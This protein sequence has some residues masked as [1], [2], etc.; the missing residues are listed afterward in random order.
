MTIKENITVD[1]LSNGNLDK[2]GYK[3]FVEANLQTSLRLINQD[4]WPEYFGDGIMSGLK[5]AVENSIRLI[6]NSLIKWDKDLDNITQGS[7]AGGKN[8][9]YEEVRKDISNF[10]FKLRNIPILVYDNGDGTYTP[11]NGRTRSEILRTHR[12]DNFICVVYQKIKGTSHKEVLNA[13]SKFSLRSNAEN[14]PAGDLMLADVYTEGCRA[15]EEDW[16]TL[17]GDTFIDNKTVKDRVDEVCGEGIFTELK[18]TYVTQQILNTYKTHHRVKSWSVTGAATDWV[19]NSKFQDIKPLYDENDNL[20]KKGLKYVVVA[21]STLEK[22]MLSVAATAYANKDYKIR[23]LIHTGTLGG[24]D[25]EENYVQKIYM[26]RKGWNEKLAESSYSFFNNKN[27]TGSIIELYGALSSVEDLGD[28]DKIK[29]FVPYTVSSYDDLI[30]Q[31]DLL[32]GL[33]EL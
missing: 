12:F 31:G 4:A 3:R 33:E 25:V 5:L 11:I 29:K 23:V 30:S 21:S 16:I 28:F 22:S 18:R 7:R 10:G 2:D 26:F 20:V 6:D 13:I 27:P 15:I 32:D 19:K 24:F 8:R 9:K 17:T 14:D 1:V